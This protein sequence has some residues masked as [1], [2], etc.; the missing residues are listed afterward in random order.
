MFQRLSV[1]KE[2]PTG[3][4]LVFQDNRTGLVDIGRA[5]V[6]KILKGGYGQYHI[7]IINGEPTIVSNP[8]KSLSNNLG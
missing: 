5:F 2:S 7:R 1:V 8:D 4:N 3:R 6:E